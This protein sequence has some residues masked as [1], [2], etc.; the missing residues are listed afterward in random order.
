MKFY[1]DF[2]AMFQA[3]SGLK[4]DMSV[5]NRMDSSVEAADDVFFF[6]NYVE[7]PATS[8]EVILYYECKIPFT[9]PSIPEEEEWE[10]D[11]LTDPNELNLTE[12]LHRAYEINQYLPDI[13]ISWNNQD[14]DMLIDGI[15]HK[16]ATQCGGMIEY[17]DKNGGVHLKFSGGPNSDIPELSKKLAERIDFALC[18]DKVYDLTNPWK[19]K[20]MMPVD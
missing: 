10:I 14:L 5:F 18:S 17:D 4:S 6:M 15:V 11:N 9:Q 7:N 16:F 19:E 20:F 2:N 13:W 12:L 3:Q 8:D 1:N